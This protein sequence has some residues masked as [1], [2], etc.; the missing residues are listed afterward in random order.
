MSD[1]S[2]MKRSETTIDILKAKKGIRTDLELA[3]QLGWSQANLSKKL[4][5]EISLKTLKDLAKFFDVHIKE[6]FK[7]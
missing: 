4:S 7:D 3:K 2:F 1:I 5:G 6:M